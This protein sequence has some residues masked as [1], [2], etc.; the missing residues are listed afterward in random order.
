MYWF[1]LL[2]ICAVTGVFSKGLWEFF[3]VRM[4]GWN[5]E[6]PV[7]DISV[8]PFKAALIALL[9]CAVLMVIAS[10]QHLFSSPVSNEVRFKM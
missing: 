9:A 6:P 3:G 1:I 10:W 8:L 4:D 2:V 5:Y 7:G